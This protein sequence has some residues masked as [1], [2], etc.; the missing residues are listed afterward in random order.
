MP[1]KPKTAPVVYET[2]PLTFYTGRDLDII[3]KIRELAEPLL[4]V[5]VE[6]ENHADVFHRIRELNEELRA[7]DYPGAFQI[8]YPDGDCTCPTCGH[9]VC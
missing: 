7:M 4:V 2:D 1:T 5:R 8:P 9:P 3:E 6:G